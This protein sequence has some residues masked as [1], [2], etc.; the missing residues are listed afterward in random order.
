M[1]LPALADS[2]NFIVQRPMI[3]GYCWAFLTI[4]LILAVNA[5][6]DHR[7]FS[8]AG[9]AALLLILVGPFWGYAMRWVILR[10][11]DR[12]DAR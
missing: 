4:V 6:W 8:K 9:F 7:Y 12:A 5:L 3:A 10:E 2:Q 1:A 11:R